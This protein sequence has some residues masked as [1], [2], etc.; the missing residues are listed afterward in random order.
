MNARMGGGMPERKKFVYFKR[1]ET[2]Q[3]KDG[4]A[5]E[6]LPL[7]TVMMSGNGRLNYVS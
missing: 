5:K 2:L 1:C 7:C 3:S 6:V 4:V